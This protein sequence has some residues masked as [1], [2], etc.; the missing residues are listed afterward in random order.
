MMNENVNQETAIKVLDFPARNAGR[1]RSFAFADSPELPSLESVLKP[2]G[3][4]SDWSYR[5]SST[6]F[7]NGYA[8][9][10]ASLR[11][12]GQVR[13]G[14][15]I[16]PSDLEG[17]LEQAER[18]ALADAVSKFAIRFPEPGERV[19]D[20]SENEQGPGRVASGPEAAS[21]H[22]MISYSQLKHAKA[23]ASRLLINADEAAEDLFGCTLSELSRDAADELIESL[24]LRASGPRRFKRAG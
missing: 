13:E 9:V 4:R 8:V 21:L 14:L 23:L 3:E 20:G 12:A 5:I 2:L 24:E 19:R 6:R 1:D 18:R 7:L 11:L 10:V 17:A 16:C 22:D 15:G